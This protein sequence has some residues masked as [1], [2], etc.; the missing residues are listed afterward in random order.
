[1]S[2]SKKKPYITD[3]QTSRKPHAGPSRAVWAKRY[4]N[5][6]VRRK[7]KE[8][9]KDE[10]AGVSNGKSYRKASCSWNIRDYSMYRP[11]DPKARRK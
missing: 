3:Q 8:A 2:R 7:T 5:K 11:K 10:A 1:M 4:A 6:V 9:L